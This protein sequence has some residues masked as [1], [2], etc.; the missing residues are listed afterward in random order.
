MI[1]ATIMIYIL[2]WTY[3]GGARTGKTNLF[4]WVVITTVTFF[5]IQF[6]WA[7]IDNF[8][9]L[10]ETKPI[11]A[12]RIAGFLVAAVMRTTLVMHVS[13]TPKNLFSHLNIFKKTIERKE[14]HLF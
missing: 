5:A 8:L 7:W 2:C 4:R 6:A 10:S 14:D 1:N 9:F 12:P 13:L 11:W 3:Q